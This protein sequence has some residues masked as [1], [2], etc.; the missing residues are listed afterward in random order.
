M[1][2][3]AKTSEHVCET[4]IECEDVVSMPEPTN[5]QNGQS[6]NQSKEGDQDERNRLHAD[7]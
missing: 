5:A 1:G 2:C 3:A 4:H 6:I 7:E